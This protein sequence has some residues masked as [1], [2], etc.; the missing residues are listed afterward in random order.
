[1]QDSL[2]KEYSGTDQDLR[3]EQCIEMMAHAS[4]TL[5][6]FKTDPV[7]SINYLERVAEMRFAI[8]EVACCINSQL[9]NGDDDKKKRKVRFGHSMPQSKIVHTLMERARKVCTDRVLNTTTFSPA[10]SVADI[11][12]PSVYFLKLL[13]RQFSFPCLRQASEKYPW[14]VPE[15]LRNSNLVLSVLSRM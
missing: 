10:G 13:V 6:K 7:I 12:G 2:F 15:G 4:D 8:M 1:M 14:I 9:F 11:V 5:K 3:F